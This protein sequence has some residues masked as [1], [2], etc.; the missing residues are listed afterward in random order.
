MTDRLE[1]LLER[2]K[3]NYGKSIKIKFYEKNKSVNNDLDFHIL[4]KRCKDIKYALIIRENTNT[5]YDIINRSITDEINKF[6]DGHIKLG[7]G[8]DL[9]FSTR[10]ESF[11]KLLKNLNGDE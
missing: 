4:N 6:K 1:N 3:E 8:Q 7:I 11:I 9:Y 2:I 5:S 10:K